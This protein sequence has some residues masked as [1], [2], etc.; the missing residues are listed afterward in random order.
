MNSSNSF[1][2][3]PRCGNANA[4]NA[5]Y[6]SRCGGQLKV[7]EEPVVCQKC[8]T[9]NTPMANYCRNCGVEL[10][11]GLATKICPKCGK[12]VD[13]SDNVCACGYSF[14][15][16]QQTNPTVK[17][18]NVS[19]TKSSASASSQKTR[20]VHN[21][22]GGRGWA[23]A[24]MVLILLFAYY[25]IA[26]YAVFK[27]DGEIAAKL[28]PVFLVNFEKG[29]IF[30][31][32]VEYTN[33]YGF[34][35]MDTLVASLINGTFAET[36]DSLGMGNILIMVLTVI[37]VV[38]ALA[39][40]IASLIRSINGKRAKQANWTFL[41]LAVLSTLI[42]GL[43]ALF[44]YVPSVSEGFL[45]KISSWFALTIGSGEEV[46][47]YSLGYAIWAIPLYFWFF[48]LYSL[49]SKAKK[50]KEKVA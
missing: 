22:K 16:L 14:V 15:T 30:C 9:R 27:A 23:I 13:A 5:K 3:C 24:A 6:C 45:A 32:G 10:K 37:F 35:Y 44:Y 50:L 40:L 33:M 17:A 41:I 2:I 18:V 7:P 20:T 8:H 1:N 28:R 46:T 21:T 36:F 31:E 34:N 19:Q 42:I 25:I 12:A 49:C 11:V 47:S 48:F 4:L 26:P 29:F 38:A 43:I 39:H